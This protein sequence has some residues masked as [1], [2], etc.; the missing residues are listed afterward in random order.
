MGVRRH[1]LKTG[2]QLSP[3]THCATQAKT[4]PWGAAFIAF[5]AY[6]FASSPSAAT[7]GD[8]AVA[9]TG[10]SRTSTAPLDISIIGTSEKIRRARGYVPQPIPLAENGPNVLALGGY[11]K[12]TV[13][14]LKGREAFLSPHIG[15]LDNAAIT[16]VTSGIAAK[17]SGSIC[18][19]Q[20]VTR[21]G[22]PG[23]SF[24]ARRI[25]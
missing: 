7:S 11:L 2:S 20:P 25:A 12:N 19:A 1:T 6:F 10:R 5:T 21:I 22:A 9:T 8:R 15:S 17:A 23:F 24:A 14:V 4:A 16:R 18:A 13:C 3:A